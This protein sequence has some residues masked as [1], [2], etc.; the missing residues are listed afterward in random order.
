[1]MAKVQ[2]SAG[3][4]LA[5]AITY[6]QLCRELPDPSTTVRWCQRVRL[7]PSDKNCSCDRAMHLV[8]RKGPEGVGWRCPRKG[9]RKEAAL[10]GGTFF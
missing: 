4:P 1:M 2:L 5:A 8:K 7:L 9:C 6:W 3:Y 10:R